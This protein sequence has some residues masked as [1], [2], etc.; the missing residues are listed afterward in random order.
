MTSRQVVSVV[1]KLLQ[2]KSD[3]SISSF[4]FTALYGFLI[5]NLI[6]LVSQ[7]LVEYFVAPLK[8]IYLRELTNKIKI[9]DIYCA[10][11]HYDLQWFDNKKGFLKAQHIE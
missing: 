3:L 11:V 7:E 6:F 1:S 4:G 8:R 5:L 2:T 9:Y 10:R